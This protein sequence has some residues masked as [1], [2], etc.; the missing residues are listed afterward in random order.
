MFFVNDSLLGMLL[1]GSVALPFSLLQCDYL[2]SLEVFHP[3][4][5]FLFAG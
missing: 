5:P 3:S 2:F 1:D 4:F